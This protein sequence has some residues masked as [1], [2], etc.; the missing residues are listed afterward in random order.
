[1]SRLWARILIRLRSDVVQPQAPCTKL[2][3]AHCPGD[4]TPE[5]RR[6]MR[7]NFGRPTRKVQH[8]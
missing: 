4:C 7:R 6:F 2:C 1:M 5:V 3:G 8:A